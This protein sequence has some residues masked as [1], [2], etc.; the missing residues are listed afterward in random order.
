MTDPL[1]PLVA[2]IA[3]Q[4]APRVAELVAEA[5]PAAAAEE[6]WRLYNLEEVA[7]M[8]G[9]STKWVRKRKDAIGWV[10]LDSTALAFEL[11]DVRRF[12]R[13]RRIACEPLASVEEPLL[14]GAFSAARR[15]TVPRVASDRAT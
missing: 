6:P 4:L 7:A 3:E 10:R 2:A 15:R 12:A 5:L 9:R 1:A 11:E 14:P 13:E 8:L